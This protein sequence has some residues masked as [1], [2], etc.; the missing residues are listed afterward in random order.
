MDASDHSTQLFIDGLNDTSS[1]VTRLVV[2]WVAVMFIVL[3][4]FLTVSVI[5]QQGLTVAGVLAIIVLALF[6]FG[7]VGALRNPPKR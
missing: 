4:G 2:L 1:G 7:I 5:S 3:F 6:A